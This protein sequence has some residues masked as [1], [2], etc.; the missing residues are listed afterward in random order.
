[1]R[2]TELA[3]KLKPFILKYVGK[4]AGTQNVADYVIYLSGS[5]CL[6]FNTRTGE[7]EFSGSNHSTVIQAAITAAGVDGTLFFRS[8]TY[9]L[10]TALSPVSGQTWMVVGVI[11]QPAGNNS[12][13]NIY[14]VDHF[15]LLGALRIDDPSSLT[16]SVPAVTAYSL[17]YAFIQ[18]VFITNY[19]RGWDLEGNT[20]GSGTNE[21]SF[22]NLYMQVRDRGIN[23]SG[24]CHDNH[25]NQVWI[26]G[27]A[28]D[29]WASGPGLRIGTGGT[30]GG[31]AFTSIQI[32]DMDKGM[33][34]P[35]AFEA[36][37]GTAII[38][39]ALGAGIYMAGACERVFFGTVWT[40]SG[41]DG[42]YIEGNPD[43]LPVSYVDKVHIGKI[44]S[45]LNA[46]YGIRLEGYVKQLTIDAAVIQR[47][48]RGLAFN[49]PSNEDVVIGTLVSLENTEFGV[50]A[51]RCGPNCMIGN[52]LIYDSIIG[53]AN[54]TKLEGSRPG[55]GQL[56]NHGVA[57]ILSGQTTVTVT[58]DLEGTPSMVWLGHESTE[59][60]GAY[61]SAK[62]STTFT[63]T[64]P[65]A[66]TANRDVSWRAISGRKAGPELVSNPDVETDTGGGVPRDWF[67]SAT[68]T[69]WS[70]AEYHTENHS[71]RLNVTAATADWR[72]LHF[73][74]NGNR[75]YRIKVMAKG[76]GSADTYLTIRWFSNTDGTGFISEQNIALSST[77][78]TWTVIEQD[79]VAP[80]TAQ[81]ADLVFR[82]PSATTADIYGDDFSIRELT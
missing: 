73:L 36:W 10:D 39:N 64:V 76:T 56:Q 26:K 32:L 33:D 49:G 19:W 42:L 18:H 65:A 62:T 3:E 78:S 45:W 61:V 5:I 81:S 27:P 51:S 15:T 35:G 38:D 69:Q 59:T 29:N 8:G 77:Y 9:T 13:L 34:L 79:I 21:N 68:G 67:A 60:T 80:G 12:I 31:N 66:V 16:T 46:N 40:A 4:G 75:T 17:R 74:V 28:P 53:Q 37:F 48:A 30:Q 11:F 52:A 72:S 47:N 70:T 57:T 71:L 55:V 25:F 20:S 82:C 7:A 58:H 54:L 1:M 14:E 2:Q 24:S 23:M 50:D 41:G 43:A 63:I 44:Y 22:Q 6:A